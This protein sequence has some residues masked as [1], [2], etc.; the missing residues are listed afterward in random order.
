MSAQEWLDGRILTREDMGSKQVAHILQ[1][2]HT[3]KPLVNQLLQLNY[4]IENPYDLL[5]DWENNAPLQIREN[6]YLQSI[7]KEL[8]RSLP[9]FRSEVATIVHGDI[10][11]S[12]WVITTSG[13]IYLV[14][15]DSVRLTDR[16]YD[17]AYLLSHYI[18]YSRWHEWLAYYGYKDNEKV[19]EKIA[20]YGQFSYLSQILNCFDKRDMEHVNQEIYGL[21]KF[22]EIVRK[23]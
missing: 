14:D 7:V 17:V 3:S 12:N 11:H 9:P 1:R 22:R 8:K 4:K 13:M 19:R 21:R 5:L 20:W 23:K 15:W 2:L 16:M 6:T 18:P 10:K